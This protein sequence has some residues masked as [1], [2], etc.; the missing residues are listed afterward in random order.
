M[1]RKY[2]VQKEI[3]HQRRLR[4]QR[5]VDVGLGMV[6]MGETLAKGLIEAAKYGQAS[7]DGHSSALKAVLTSLEESKT[8]N[9]AILKSIA[10]SADVN[11]QILLHLQKQ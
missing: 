9:E 6:Q 10:N 11:R 8:V 1:K 7:G 5:K 4:K 3:Q 2:E